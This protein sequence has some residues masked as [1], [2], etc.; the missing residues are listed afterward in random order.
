[1]NSIEMTLQTEV[2]RHVR[3]EANGR[4]KAAIASR[5]DKKAYSD[6]TGV[7][8]EHGNNFRGGQGNDERILDVPGKGQ[9][10]HF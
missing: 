5:A 2:T 3:N 6:R 8:R 1:M 4:R 7:L 10:R 9:R